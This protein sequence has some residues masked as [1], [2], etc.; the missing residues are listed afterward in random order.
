MK[1][2]L[3][4]NGFDLEH[5]LPTTYKDFLDFCQKARKIF[6]LSS[7][8]TTYQYCKTLA[9][10]DTAPS[11]IAAL[12]LSFQTRKCK[13]TCK[14]NSFYTE[15]TTQNPAL[16]ELFE[17]IRDNIW[18]QYFEKRCSCLGENWIDFESEISKVIQAL[19][20]GRSQMSNGSYKRDLWIGQDP[21]DDI[22][23][24]F[25]KEFKDISEKGVSSVDRFSEYLM[26][27]LERLTRALEIYLAE[28]V[29]KIPITEKSADI[30]TIHPDCILSFNYSN[31]YERVYGSEEKII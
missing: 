11:I 12:K 1:I 16:D 21:L 19:E 10:L 28:F 18:L 24:N 3:I 22:L 8:T 26:R 30:E 17:L 31:T 25:N 6:T 27:E 7:E 5:H 20:D 13:Q 14:E 23:R 29:Q 9:D 2:L 4:G 15:V